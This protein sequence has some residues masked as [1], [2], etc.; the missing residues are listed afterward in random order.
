M[1]S[2]VI[3][4]KQMRRRKCTIKSEL[5]CPRINPE[6]AYVEKVFV[7]TPVA[8]S[9]L[10]TFIWTA[11]KSLAAKIRLVHE[12]FLCNL[13]QNYTQVDDISR[14]GL[15]SE[16][17]AVFHCV[18]HHFRTDSK[19]EESVLEVCH[20]ICSILFNLS[21]SISESCITTIVDLISQIH[22]GSQ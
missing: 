8:G 17:R 13:I 3:I 12:H 10:A 6:I 11:P 1:R 15:W 14:R 22:S 7:Y 20:S 5:T 4:L 16:I 21:S 18:K 9:M 19:T 2:V